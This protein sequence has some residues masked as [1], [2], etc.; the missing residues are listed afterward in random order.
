MHA[1]DNKDG[2]EDHQWAVLCHHMDAVGNPQHQQPET[3]HASGKHSQKSCRAK[4]MQRPGKITKQ[5]ADRNQIK[6]DR[7]LAH[8]S[9]L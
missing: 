6:Y 1:G 2:G 5:K 7:Q 4:Q 3:K 8:H 9:V